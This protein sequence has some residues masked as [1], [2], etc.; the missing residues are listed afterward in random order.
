MYGLPLKYG[1]FFRSDIEPD[2]LGS[3]LMLFEDSKKLKAHALHHDLDTKGEGRYSH[4]SSHLYFSSSDGSDP[5]SNNHKYHYKIN[6]D[7]LAALACLFPIGLFL[8]IN[9]GLSGPSLFYT[10]FGTCFF[11]FSLFLLKNPFF[12]YESY[13]AISGQPVSDASSW[14]GLARSLYHGN[15]FGTGGWAA[16]RGGYPLILAT[17]YNL[18]G[19]YVYVAKWLNVFFA[20]LGITCVFLLFKELLNTK[21]ACFTFTMLLLEPGNYNYISTSASEVVGNALLFA[22]IYIFILTLKYKSSSLAFF[23]GF[24]FVLSNLTRTL[25]LLA[26]PSYILLSA[27][28]FHKTKTRLKLQVA[29]LI[30]YSLGVIIVFGGWILRQNYVHGIWSFSDNTSQAFYANTDPKYGKWSPQIYEE[31]KSL[32]DQSIKSKYEFFSQKANENIKKYPRFFL[33]QIKNNIVT[34][35]SRP[36]ENFKESYYLLLLTGIFCVFFCS[37]DLFRAKYLAGVLKFFSAISL[38]VAI[39]LYDLSLVIISVSC[40]YILIRKLQEFI[41]IIPLTIIFSSLAIGLVGVTDLNRLWATIS[42]L[43]LFLF[44]YTSFE[45]SNQITNQI[46]RIKK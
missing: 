19:P 11:V 14:D 40:L 33:S 43:P 30:F 39:N 9:A 21:W 1:R 46:M 17:A 28:Y 45:F 15:G 6:F 25:T 5:R 2:Q 27:Y 3:S 10:I 12:T 38:L 20:S 13:M 7:L 18:F 26:L 16:R 24:I 29:I 23:A 42:I 44:F 4:W 31:L 22:S 8:L 37:I 35:L 36:F 41:V 34:F 32:K